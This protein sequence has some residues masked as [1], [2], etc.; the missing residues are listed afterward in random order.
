MMEDKLTDNERLRLEALKQAV[1]TSV[2]CLETNDEILSRA[3]RYHK[4]IQS[5]KV[6]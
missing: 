3:K 2:G 5:G 1:A 4:Y 6:E